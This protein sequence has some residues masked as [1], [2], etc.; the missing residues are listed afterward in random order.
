MQNVSASNVRECNVHV[1]CTPYTRIIIRCISS[2]QYQ[3]VYVIFSQDF[4][5]PSAHFIH[6]NINN[7][8]I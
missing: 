1:N 6:V 7:R 5:Y 8:F 2:V 4:D 3:I